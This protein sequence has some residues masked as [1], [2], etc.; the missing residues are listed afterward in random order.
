MHGECITNF[1]CMLNT[2]KTVKKKYNFSNKIK[3]TICRLYQLKLL[4]QPKLQL[5]HE[6]S[7]LLAHAQSFQSDCQCENWR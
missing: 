5:D 4:M 2:I 6:T 1:I 7:P 3:F